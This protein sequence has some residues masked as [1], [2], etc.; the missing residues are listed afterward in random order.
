MHDLPEHT[1]GF[2]GLLHGLSRPASRQDQSGEHDSRQKRRSAHD[3]TSNRT[4]ISNDDERSSPLYHRS[5]TPITAKRPRWV[6][7]KW[8]VVVRL[9]GVRLP[10]GTWNGFWVDYG[11]HGL[12]RLD[13]ACRHSGGV[14]QRHTGAGWTRRRTERDNRFACAGRLDGVRLPYGPRNGFGVDYGNH[15]LVRLDG[16]RLSRADRGTGCGVRQPVPVRLGV[17]GAR[18]CGT[19][20]GA[21]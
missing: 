19:W 15:G 8:I 17:P 11:N 6:L 9:D 3:P 21:D 7:H 18:S 20:T 13:G 12:V 14:W 5:D 10:C 1:D 16:A 2:P 4:K